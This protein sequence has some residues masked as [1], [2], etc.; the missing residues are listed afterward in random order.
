MAIGRFLTE[1]TNNAPF[2]TRSESEFTRVYVRDDSRIRLSVWFD[3]FSFH[4]LV[5]KVD[6]AGNPYK[7]KLLRENV[8]LV[9]AIKFAEEWISDNV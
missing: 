7:G 6:S 9:K 8:R 3:G 4:P 2:Y 5:E 1:D